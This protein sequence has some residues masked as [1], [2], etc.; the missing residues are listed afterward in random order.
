MEVIQIISQTTVPIIFISAIGLLTLTFQNRYARIKDSV[1]A[2]QK[3]RIIYMQSSEQ[4]KA[5]EAEKMLMFYQK[6]A[7]MIKDAMLGAFFSILFIALT[8]FLI[9]IRGIWEIDSLYLDIPLL[10]SFTFA[11]LSLVVSVSLIIAAMVLS[12]KTLN[13]EVKNDE[14]G[15]RFGL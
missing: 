3:Q 15:I 14:D 5:Q 11:V 10:L 6:E 4:Q 1:Y 2:F 9:M 7:K 12:V 8:S 13:Y